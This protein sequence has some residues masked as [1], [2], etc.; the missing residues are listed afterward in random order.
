MLAVLFVAVTM[1]FS[2]R[3]S[4]KT[5]DPVALLIA[6]LLL[7]YRSKTTLAPDCEKLPVLRDAS[8][9][10]VITIG[11]ESVEAEEC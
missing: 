7:S 8:A 4:H 1:Q 6:R 9:I 11:D 2:L 10:T 3:T 5:S